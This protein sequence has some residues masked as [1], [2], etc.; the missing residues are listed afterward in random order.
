MPFSVYNEMRWG[1]EK[2]SERP[3]SPSPS[4]DGG[5]FQNPPRPK[6][7]GKHSDLL[8]MFPLRR[9]SSQVGKF[10]S[11]WSVL[12]CKINRNILNIS[13]SRGGLAVG[14]TFTILVDDYF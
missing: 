3:H 2:V 11:M 12:T 4:L 7:K 8:R 9:E 5:C 14:I 10:L 1:V 6:R 13:A